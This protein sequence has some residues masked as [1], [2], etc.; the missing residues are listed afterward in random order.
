L[1][2]LRGTP[3]IYY[4]DEIGMEQV[5]LR[6]DQVRDLFEMR[7]PGRGLGRD[8]CRTP[9]QWD[10]TNG[11]G[12]SSAEPW[13]PV[14]GSFRE[15][16]V[17]N[18][19]GDDASIYELYRRLIELRRAHPAL[20]SGRY[21]PIVAEGDLLLF[22]RELGRTQILVALNLGRGPVTANFPSGS[23]T[24]RMLLSSFADRVAERL[25]DSI[26]LRPNEG[27]V[28]EICTQR[29]LPNA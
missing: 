11:A 15:V 16:N 9:M 3:T 21:R 23:F 20:A 22:I 18:Q 28:I 25:R 2:T 17:L 26:E 8:G 19:R 5:A 10:D 12:F 1:L 27:I 29:M 7:V 6:P 13:L 14:A 4:G 24:G